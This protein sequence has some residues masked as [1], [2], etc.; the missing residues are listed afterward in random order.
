MK[1]INAKRAGSAAIALTLAACAA[2][3]PGPTIPVAPGPG[4]SF[5][6]FAAE[7]AACEQYASARTAP[8]VAAAN[9][10]GFGT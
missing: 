4:K 2:P 7:Q 10:Q 1:F 3:P 8:G 5:D 6:Q 9:N